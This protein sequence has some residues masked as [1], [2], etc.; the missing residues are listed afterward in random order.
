ML[1]YLAKTNLYLILFYC[2]YRLFLSRH[3]FFQWNR[4]YLLGAIA[5]SFLL[6]AIVFYTEAALPVTG[7]EPM[8]TVNAPGEI[9]RVAEETNY[10]PAML[11]GCYATG[12]LMMLARLLKSIHKILVLIKNGEHIEL[13]DFTLILLSRE[14]LGNG[15]SGSFSFFR[16]MIVNRQ[17]YENN[18][19]PIFR[20]EH[21]HIRQL[22][23]ADILLIECLKVI[24][25]INPVVWLYKRSM[26]AVHEYLADTEASDRESYAEFLIAYAL[27]VPGRMLG[28]H[29]SN[30]SLLKDRIKMI[31]KNRT[32]NWLLSKYLLILPLTALTV[33]FTAARKNI[34]Q[35]VS[36]ESVVQENGISIQGTVSDQNGKKIPDAIVIV[37]NR[38][39]GAATDLNGKFELKNIAENASLVVSHIQ[40]KSREIAVR[41]G[42]ASYDVVIQRDESVSQALA[43]VK[44]TTAPNPA[45]NRVESKSPDKNSFKTAGQKPEFPGG[46]AAMTEYLRSSMK[47]PA[48]ALKANV[49]GVVIVRFV[50]DKEGAL[51]S[52]VIVKGVGFGLD[53]E[54]VRLV[55]DMPKWKPGIQNGQPIEMAQTIEIKFDLAAAK[56]DKRQGFRLPKLNP[57]L[58]FRI[59]KVKAEDIFSSSLAFFEPKTFNPFQ[60][61]PK[62]EYRFVPDSSHY[63]FM[64]YNN[65]FPNYNKVAFRTDGPVNFR[66]YSK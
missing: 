57:A 18:P 34:P 52:V 49:E 39:Q 32:P 2:N 11:L 17:D 20:H 51:N 12:V 46:H 6:P 54:S 9:I 45:D 16:W 60:N 21:L 44:N 53:A 59:V 37:K 27:K 25:W 65:S 29:F 10:W 19:D 15:Y 42:Q 43:P 56:G 62:A 48:A 22:H 33:L 64:N 66:N 7:S 26:Q 8:E 5:A 50:V 40:Y 55:K 38:T 4:F 35:P 28:N 31:Y 30:S 41:K 1:I 36:A 3:T 13:E 23:S 24:F 47:Y 58:N 63:R 14:Q 61:P